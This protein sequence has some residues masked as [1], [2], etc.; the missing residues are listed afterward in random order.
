MTVMALSCD[1]FFAQVSFDGAGLVP[2][3]AQD[4][5]SGDVLMMAWMNREALRLTLESG[6]VTYWSR[7]RQALWRKGETSGHIQRLAS[8][9]LDC[10]GDT[11]LM[12]VRQSGPACHTGAPTCFFRRGHV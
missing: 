7:S 3:I 5:S 4:V 1:D 11:I 9:W 12:K 2:A 10:D 6:N 8:I